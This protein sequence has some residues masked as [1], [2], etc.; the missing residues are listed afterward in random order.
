MQFPWKNNELIIG[1]ERWTYTG[2]FG[3]FVLN[4]YAFSGMSYS[5]ADT[6]IFTSFEDLEDYITPDVYQ[7]CIKHN[8]NIK[9]KINGKIFVFTGKMTYKRDVLEKMVQDKGGLV[10]KDVK[11]ITDYL[12]CNN[13]AT[14]KY[15]K[16]KKYN[17]LVISEEEFLVMA[18]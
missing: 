2:H 13:T 6:R 8:V 4:E 11:P 7:A 15:T 12:V 18:E 14:V 3:N 1:T 5:H 17:T 9:N 10:S 16:A